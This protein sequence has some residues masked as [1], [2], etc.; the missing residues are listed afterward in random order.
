MYNHVSVF[1]NVFGHFVLT[2]VCCPRHKEHMLKTDPRAGQGL[3]R[4]LFHGTPGANIEDICHNNI[5]PRVAGVNGVSFGY[6]AYFASNA[7]YSNSYASPSAGSL[8]QHMFLAKVLVGK[9]VV[10]KA[11]GRRP[12]PVSKNNC[13]LYD[14]C[15][16]SLSNPSIFVVFDR[17][18]C[19]PYYLIKYRELPM[20]MELV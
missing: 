10:G 2:S 4:H 11:K 1:P 20:V 15:V 8:T 16:D 7:K 6:G 17:C 5:D 14:S 19:Y 18:Q 3:E 13:N 9:M 12:P